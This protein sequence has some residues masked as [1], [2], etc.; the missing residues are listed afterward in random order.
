M[1]TEE[2]TEIK[3]ENLVKVKSDYRVLAQLIE[4]RM[5]YIEH[6][7]KGVVGVDIQN[8]FVNT[9]ELPKEEKQKLRLK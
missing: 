7:T 8:I 1:N 3:F 4:G 9:V 5:A 6:P 2:N